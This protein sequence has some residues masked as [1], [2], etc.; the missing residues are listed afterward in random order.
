MFI[1]IILVPCIAPSGAPLNIILSTTSRNISVAWTAIDCIQRNGAI[2]RYTVAFQEEGEAD[3]LEN[4]VDTTF[5][6]EELTPGNSYT[7]RVAGV[8]DVGSGP[9]AMITFTT[10]EEGPIC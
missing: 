3:V 8:N 4:T 5:N 1:I 2:S 6:A 7:F 9:F 10:N